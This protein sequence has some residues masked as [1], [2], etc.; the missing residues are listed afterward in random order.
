L[1]SKKRASGRAR[2]EHT[3]ERLEREASFGIDCA[4]AS[5]EQAE[6]AVLDV[7]VGVTPTWSMLIYPARRPR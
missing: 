4:V 2:A 7:S 6:L 3:A 1:L 5:I